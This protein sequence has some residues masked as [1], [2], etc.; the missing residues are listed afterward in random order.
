MNTKAVLSLLGLILVVLLL[1]G[2]GQTEKVL[3]V[4]DERLQGEA[5]KLFITEEVNVMVEMIEEEGYEVVVASPSGEPIVADTATLTPDMM[6]ADANA[7]DYVGFVFPCMGQPDNPPERDADALRLAREAAQQEKPI[8]A[9][10]GGVI[11]LGQAGVLDGKEY[12]LPL[13][14][15]YLIPD[16]IHAGTGLAQDGNIITSGTCP[17]M[18]IETGRPDQTTELAQGFIDMLASAKSSD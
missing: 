4:A 15:M 16:G 3:L 17:Y 14:M 10:V 5:M 1:A 6:L 7:D 2:C 11:T 8:A 9:Q 18:A 12:A 13:A